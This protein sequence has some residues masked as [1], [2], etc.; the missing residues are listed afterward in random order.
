MAQGQVPSQRYAR[1]GLFIASVSTRPFQH[2]RVR[3]AYR[4]LGS[5]GVGGIYVRY[6]T[7]NICP[8]P[9]VHRAADP[10]AQP[11]R[12]SGGEMLLVAEVVGLSFC[13]Q[14]NLTPARRRAEMQP[15]QYGPDLGSRQWV[16]IAGSTTACCTVTQWADTKWK[17]TLCARPRPPGTRS[18]QVVPDSR[19]E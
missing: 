8:C 14:V 5:W 2:M 1:T 9:H 16:D 12:C 15:F 17:G 10:T 11:P 13:V 18:V 4:E 3:L 7:N 6:L 19:V